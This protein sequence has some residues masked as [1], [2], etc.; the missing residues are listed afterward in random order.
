VETITE[1]QT[2][3]FESS[4]DKLDL[5]SVELGGPG[6]FG[7]LLRPVATGQLQVQFVQLGIYNK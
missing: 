5:L 6:Q 1:R 4:V 2:N 3:L 7:Q